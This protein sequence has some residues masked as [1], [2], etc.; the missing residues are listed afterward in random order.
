MISDC[1]RECADRVG[2]EG[3]KR[4]RISVEA[5]IRGLCS[6]GNG[7]RTRDL[8]TTNATLYRLSH[9]SIYAHLSFRRKLYSTIGETSMQ[10]KS[11]GET[12]L[13]SPALC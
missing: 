10:A 4:P 3:K 5:E 8:R 9:A 7:N 11:A 1:G 13:V 12:K 2:T 6:A